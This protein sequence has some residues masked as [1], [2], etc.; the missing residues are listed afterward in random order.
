M[1]A[2]QPVRIGVIGGGLMGRE[3]AVVCGRWN[4]L[5]DHPSSPSVVAAAV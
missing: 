3:L 2:Q 1:S 4:Q 5:V